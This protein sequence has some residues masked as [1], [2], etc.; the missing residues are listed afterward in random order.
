[1][2]LIPRHGR[3]IGT[4][5]AKS[6]AS[7]TLFTATGGVQG[8]RAVG[9]RIVFASVPSFNSRI[10]SVAVNHNSGRVL[11]AV[12]PLLQASGSQSVPVASL[13]GSK[14]LFTHQEPTRSELRLRDLGSGKETVLHAATVRGKISPDGSKVA[15]TDNAT[16]RL[17]D[18]SGGEATKVAEGSPLS[19]YGWT[20]DGNFLIYYMGGSIRWFT[21]DLATRKSTVLLAHPKLTIHGVEPSPDRRWVSFHIPNPVREPIYIASVRDGMV[22]GESEWIRV[23]DSAGVNRRPWWSPDGNLLYWLSE[24]DGFVCAWALRLEP[25]TKKPKGDPFAVLHFHE[26]RRS[27]AA[28][29]LASFG[30]AITRDKLIFALPEYSGNIW[31][32]EKEA[33]K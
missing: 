6:S 12:E 18:A 4:N 5:L 32:A 9:G 29:G 14:L 28:V 8:S 31:I 13:N 7:A 16:I 1:M 15:F 17:M 19:L 10:W 25:A 22:A 26:A 20:A 3:L 27:L 24:R 33:R 11:G 2:I 30:P 23:A 21:F